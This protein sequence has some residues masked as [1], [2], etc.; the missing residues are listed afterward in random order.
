MNSVFSEISLDALIS[1]DAPQLLRGATS[2]LVA[3]S[4]IV[5]RMSGMMVIGPIFGHPSL[6]MQ[7]RVLI[8]L[9]ASLVITPALAQ[10]NGSRTFQLLDRNHDQLLT[11]NELPGSI[12]PEFERLSAQAGKTGDAGLSAD[13][14]RLPLPL[15]ATTIEWAWLALVEFA[16]GA[17]LG[18]GVMTIVS[19]LQM[20]GSL[21]DAQLGTSLASVFNP[22]VNSDVSV[23]GELLYQLGLVVF[24][25]AGGHHLIVS[26]LF[27]T[28]QALPVGYAQVSP[29]ALELLS[30]L[31][32]QSLVL[33][34]R[35]SAP[36]L[37]MMA[38][39]GLALGFLGRTVPQLNVLA[40]GFPVR[41]LV[42]LVIFGLALPGIAE[43]VARAL[44]AGVQQLRDVL[45]G[46]G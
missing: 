34:L 19:G 24:L 31:V 37:G 25:I 28:F 1:G 7:V 4:L 17:A 38:V 3:F 40:V 21:I 33:A 8:I 18:L 36:V 32:H 13:D 29:P 14:F 11:P 35:I 43:A 2:V 44:P 22:Q 10:S 27:D 26:A 6:P 46:H 30:D 39:V 15:P 42:G 12:V 9:G 20:A 45:T 23:S 16:V 41:L 5:T